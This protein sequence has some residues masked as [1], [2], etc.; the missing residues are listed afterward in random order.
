M[1]PGQAADC[2][3]EIAINDVLL[4][5]S[6]RQVRGWPYV[7]GQSGQPAVA[8]CED[9]PKMFGTGFGV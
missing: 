7:K 6:S 3:K 1:V 4:P 2:S 8:R 9:V 5:K